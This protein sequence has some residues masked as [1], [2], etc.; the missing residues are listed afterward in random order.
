[1]FLSFFTVLYWFCQLSGAIFIEPFSPFFEAIKGITHIFYNRKIVIA[2][3]SI[4]FA[5]LIASFVMLFIVWALKFAV[6]YLERIEAK[7]DSAYKQAKKRAEE[8]FNACLKQEYINQ[9][10]KNKNIAFIVK[11]S[12]VNLLKDSFFNKDKDV[13]VEEIQRG[14]LLELLQNMEIEGELHFEKRILDDSVLLSFHPFKDIDNIL[15][16]I[17]SYIENIKQKYAQNKWQIN[18]FIGIEAYAKEQELDAK[19]KSLI[20]LVRLGL[21]N[22]IV[23]FATFK[24]RYSLIKNPEHSIEQEGLYSINDVDEEVFCVKNLK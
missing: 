7:Y 5:F 24:Q 22:K 18:Y 12:A 20:M 16:S 15:P 11:F 1:V 9:E 10:Q 2:K 21:T 14:A 19:M 6:E 3:E 8:V 13:G 4:D 23:C 17:K